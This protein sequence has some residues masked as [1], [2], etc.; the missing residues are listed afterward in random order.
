MDLQ[1]I[2][3]PES[4]RPN[5]LD[6]LSTGLDDP[7]LTELWVT[8][9]WVHAPGV[10]LLAP[11]LRRFRARG[12][13]A[14]LICGL[15]RG[16][17][18]VEG[19]EAALE[20]FDHVSVAFDPSGRTV[21]G[22]FYLFLGDAKASML[23]GS[24]NLTA[25]GLVRNHEVGLVVTGQP[26][27]PVIVDAQLYLH[28][29]LADSN[30]VKELDRTL[31][32]RL[33]SSGQ[34][35]F[36]PP[37]APTHPAGTSSDVDQVFDPSARAFRSPTR[38]SPTGV[39]RGGTTSA[40]AGLSHRPGP[41]A[42]TKRWFKKLPR[43]DAQRLATSNPSNTVTLVRAGHA[44]DPGTWFRDDVFG[45]QPWVSVDESGAHQRALVWFD[46]HGLGT[47]FEEE[48]YVE[49]NLRHDSGQNNRVA[50]IRWGELTRDLLRHSIDVT[51][52]VITLERLEDDTF[53]LTFG[54]AATGSFVR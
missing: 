26:S 2:G 34:V 23:V 11:R 47:P 42:A 39:P 38:R 27:T 19:L 24:Q 51:G 36:A 20:E 44:I 46:V 17:A 49:Y 4:G 10:G 6:Y 48:M 37:G 33:Q 3:Q 16:A 40:G 32:D 29:L 52:W 50:S 22:K 8:T 5:A 35:T 25:G 13:Q 7:F 30:I 18:T 28:R 9:A 43:S 15:S 12:G 54:D 14:S 31:L 1:F 45:D 53:R 21:H 41:L